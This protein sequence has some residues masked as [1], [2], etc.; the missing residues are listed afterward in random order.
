MATNYGKK[1]EKVFEQDWLRAFPGSFIMRLPDQQ[2]GY[3]G[4]SAN[5]C[6]YICFVNGTLHLIELKSHNGNTF[7]LDN[8]RQ[9]EKLQQYSGIDGVKIGVIIWYRDHD[10]VV[11]CPFNSILKM[12]MDDRKSVNIKYLDTKEYELIEIPSEKK[13]V[14]LASDYKCLG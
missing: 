7:P 4:T 6:D 5:P 8:L 1:F 14:F 10:K 11:Y 2:S 3:Y 13:R 12:K 9:F